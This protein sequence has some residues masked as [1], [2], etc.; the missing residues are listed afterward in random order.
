MAN[1]RS[2]QDTSWS[3]VQAL[4]WPERAPVQAS[5]DAAGPYVRVEVEC[6]AGL[7]VGTALHEWQRGEVDAV[8]SVG[9]LE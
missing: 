8:V 3:L 7:T 6:E 1:M 5:L 9:P 4:G 2:Q